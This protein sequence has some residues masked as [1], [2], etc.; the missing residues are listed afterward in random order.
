MF[1]AT[2]AK[3]FFRYEIAVA[4]FITVCLVSAK[5]KRLSIHNGLLHSC[6]NLTLPSSWRDSLSSLYTLIFHHMAKSMKNAS[7]ANNSNLTC[8]PDCESVNPNFSYLNLLPKSEQNGQGIGNIGE[9]DVTGSNMSGSDNNVCAQHNA[10][11]YNHGIPG[12]Q[13]HNVNDANYSGIGYSV[14]INQCP[15]ELIQSLIKLI[16]SIN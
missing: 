13:Q 12:V 4:I 16:K 5:D 9:S 1:A 7:K 14:T 11:S 8:T 3:S 2:S 10:V 6:R 15:D